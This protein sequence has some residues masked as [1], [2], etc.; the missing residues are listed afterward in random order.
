MED[1]KVKQIL[2]GGWHQWEW[3]GY[4]EKANMVKKEKYV[5]MY[6]NGKMRPVET[7]SGMGG[8]DT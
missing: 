2:S 3:E 5:F 4:K 6:K 1:R 7:I 8:K